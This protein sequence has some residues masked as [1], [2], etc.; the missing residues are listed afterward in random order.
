MRHVDI[1][2]GDADG[3]IAR[4]QF[5]LAHPVAKNELTLI[6]GVKRDIALVAQASPSTAATTDISI[7][8]ISFDSNIDAIQRLLMQGA[9]LRYFDHHRADK[10]FTHPKL[11]AH[12]DTASNICTSLIVD[13]TLG[14]RYRNWAIA[15]TFGDNLTAVATRLAIYA[16]L[17]NEQIAN[18]RMLGECI[19][20]NAYGE[21]LRDL[22][23]PPETIAR[24]I[25][26][27]IDPFE[28][29]ADNT[30]VRELQA[31]AQDDLAQAELTPSLHATLNVAVYALPNTAWARRVI[32][33]FANRL[34]A[35][36]PARA[37]SVL[38][39]RD[40]GSYAASIRAPQNLPE[41]A[42]DVAMAFATGGGRKSAAGIN[43]L[44]ANEVAKLIK[45]MEGVWKR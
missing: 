42:D 4:H 43:H 28:F 29:L 27:F 15:A 12:I 25:A 16:K 26:P 36:Y 6:T 21:T 41:H 7:F 11:A 9:S 37:H 44:P 38:A 3:I 10:L 32:G 45:R 2:N 24:R 31:G 39:E 14:G 8:D 13:N 40:D 17:N 22:H 23:F 34:T 20:Y 30:I 35:A 18:L 1:F 5:R 33:I 19:N